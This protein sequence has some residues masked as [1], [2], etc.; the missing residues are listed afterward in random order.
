MKKK[1]IITVLLTVLTACFTIVQARA[2]SVSLDVLDSY[3]EVGETFDVEVWVDGEGIGEVLLAFGFDVDTPG[4]YFS[5]TGYA[6]GSDFSDASD[7]F[8]P[9]NVA[10]EGL[11]FDDDVLLATLSFIAI[12]VGTDSLGVE[13]LYDGFF[14]GLFYGVSGLDISALTDITIH[15]AGVPIPE[16]ATM[17]LLAS[18]L[19]GLAGFRKKLKKA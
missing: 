19:A 4:T 9:D 18:G 6:M 5:Y 16:P 2:V 11:V 12:D 10:G 13:G 17:L 14:Y 15:E 3:I 8:N 7:P 1:L